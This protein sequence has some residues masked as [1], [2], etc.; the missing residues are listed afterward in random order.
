MVA[1]AQEAVVINYIKLTE[2]L[3]QRK[4]MPFKWGKNDCCL[5]AA[6]WVELVSG[7]DPAKSFRGQYRTK[8]GAFKQLFKLGFKDIKSV[9]KASLNHEIE[10]LYAQRGD[11]ALVNHGGEL[12]GGII[13]I[14][15]V[16]C[17]GEHGLIY[18]P[19]D[20]VEMV[21]TLRISNE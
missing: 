6:D 19:I 10:P 13:Q 16:A 8:N 9:F 11:I 15:R 12:V 17:V 14:N 3:A 2:F 18:L 20:A 1:H 4:E 7:Q 21:F 5:F